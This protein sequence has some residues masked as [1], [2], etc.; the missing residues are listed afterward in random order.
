MIRRNLELRR[1][2]RAVRLRGEPQ[3]TLGPH[4]PGNARGQRSARQTIVVTLRSRQW[5]WRP[6]WSFAGRRLFGLRLS[7]GSAAGGPSVDPNCGDAPGVAFPHERTASSLL[8]AVRRY[9]WADQPKW[10]TPFGANQVG[11]PVSS[12]A[13]R[14]SCGLNRSQPGQRSRSAPRCG[15]I[16][17]PFARRGRVCC[18]PRRGRIPRNPTRL[19][20][21]P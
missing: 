12:S 13:L 16:G 15:R 1:L 2:D 6:G 11:R 7:G 8:T 3:T 18:R 5:P 14:G 4:G 17:A 20:A 10:A 19:I 9:R 21:S